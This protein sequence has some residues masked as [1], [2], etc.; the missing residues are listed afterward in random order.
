M[1]EKKISV[2]INTYN[3]HQYLEE[4]LESVKDFDEVLVCDMESTDDTCAIAK[5]HGCRI[6]IFPKGELRIVEPARQ[7]AIHEALYPWVLVID[8]DELATPQLRDC[9]YQHIQSGEPADGLMI[10][11]KNR[12]MNRFMHGYYPDYN[13]RFFRKAVTTWA[14]VIHSQPK[15]QGRID[16]LPRQRKELAIDHLDNRSIKERLAKIN[17][18]TEYELEKRKDRHY[19]VGAFIYRPLVRFIKC[20]ILKGGFRDGVP[21]LLF[22]WLEA[23]QQF[24]I[25]AKLYERKKQQ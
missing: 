10:P 14:P 23:V 22:A 2:V 3:A 20:Y 5:A 15:V 25:L 1:E 4:V 21:G 24:T 13:L 18:Y 19:G 11:R 9:L 6:V 12:L 8:A 17:L 7:F 16:R